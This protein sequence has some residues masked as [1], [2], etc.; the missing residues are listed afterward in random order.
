MIE[1]P[2]EF[3]RELQ[4]RLAAC[5]PTNCVNILDVPGVRETF[6]QTHHEIAADER[7]HGATSAGNYWDLVM[8]DWSPEENAVFALAVWRED[9]LSVFTG[10]GGRAAVLAVCDRFSLAK[11]PVTLAILLIVIWLGLLAT[12]KPV[13]ERAAGFQ[14]RRATNAEHPR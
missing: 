1:S 8:A 3:E 6:A 2:S 12:W 4:A 14:G 10:A 7:Q 5:A 13:A 11:I 9:A